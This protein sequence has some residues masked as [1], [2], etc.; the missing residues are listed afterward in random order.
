MQ[1]I[2]V[3]HDVQLKVGK[4]VKVLNVTKVINLHA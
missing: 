1:K 2:K 4:G 3:I